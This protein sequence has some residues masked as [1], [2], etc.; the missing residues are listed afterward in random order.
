V[1]VLGS[2]VNADVIHMLGVLTVCIL[3]VPPGA[4]LEPGKNMTCFVDSHIL[5]GRQAIIRPILLDEIVD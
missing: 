1:T 2:R 3:V 5:L 4:V